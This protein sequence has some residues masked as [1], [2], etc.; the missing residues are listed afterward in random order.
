MSGQITLKPPKIKL[1]ANPLVRQTMLYLLLWVV[2]FGLL[3]VLDG[4]LSAN[5][6]ETPGWEN[7]RNQLL[8][9]LITTTA[10]GTLNWWLLQRK[11]LTEEP[12]WLKTGLTVLVVLLAFLLMIF[13]GNFSGNYFNMLIPSML[14]F[15]L[16]WFTMLAFRAHL[17]VPAWHFAPIEVE[18]LREYLGVMSF[19]EDDTRG[20][21]W[22]FGEDFFGLDESGYY[23]FRTYTPKNVM[24]VKIDY[25]FKGLLA[26]HNYNMQPD[27][28]LDFA[29][30]SWEFHHF[31]PWFFPKG[32]RQMNPSQ[33]L[34][35]NGLR[36][37]KLTAEQRA[38]MS[39]LRSDLS[40]DFKY[41]TI[42][43]KRI[44]KETPPE[45]A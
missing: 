28:P 39:N 30:C 35:E 4:K 23:S 45:T 9:L 7:P 43:I 40:D 22:V 15:A 5:D 24:E 36:F 42:F 21:K 26:F 16:P 25:L 2:L 17:A 10:F 13:R 14:F 20:I 1:L 3:S 34:A 44:R 11:M 32:E 33:T 18:G 19:S 38:S 31:S 41:A 29:D 8:F 6:G 27:K 12:D 37:Q